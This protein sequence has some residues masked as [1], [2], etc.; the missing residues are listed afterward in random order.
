[1]HCHFISQRTK[2][3]FYES[4]REVVYGIG[5]SLVAGA[6]L[7]AL[8]VSQWDSRFLV[9][10]QGHTL[11]SHCE[12]GIFDSKHWTKSTQIRLEANNNCS[13]YGTK[14]KSPFLTV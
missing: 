1:M 11:K 14:V 7:S 13:F 10:P 2:S 3:L 8:T 5:E 6:D 4:L 9:N 12:N